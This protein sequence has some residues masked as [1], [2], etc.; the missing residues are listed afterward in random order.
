MSPD[1]LLTPDSAVTMH[2]E[3]RRTWLYVLGGLVLIC[4]MTGISLVVGGFVMF[5]RHVRTESIGP[6]QAAVEFEQ[7]AA[8]FANSIPLIELRE[9][10]RMFVR[11]SP[12]RPRQPI[13]AL[14][15]LIYDADDERL[16]RVT[17]P[18]WLLRLAPTSNGHT[19]IHIDGVDGLD[20]GENPVSLEDL[21]RHGPGLIVDG[22]DRRRRGRLLAWVD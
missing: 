13:E 18:G 10:E 20:D 8:R 5:N 6:A 22:H 15:L 21:E 9:G 19:A 7:T 16:V 4:M 3:R 11:R 1:T 2:R 12:E 14:H 17:V